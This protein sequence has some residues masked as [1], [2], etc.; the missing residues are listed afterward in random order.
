M[1]PADVTHLA[2]GHL[3]LRHTPHHHR[4]TP[5]T[6][7]HAV[8]LPA[9]RGVYEGQRLEAVCGGTVRVEQDAWYDMSLTAGP[10]A[11]YPRGVQSVTCKD[12][13]RKLGL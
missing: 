5:G 7:T 10:V 4:R 6:R 1:T 2:S 3:T 11:D 9:G 13:R 8:V 12:C